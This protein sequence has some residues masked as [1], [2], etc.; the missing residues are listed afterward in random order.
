M[1]RSYAMQFTWFS[2]TSYLNCVCLF[3][4]FL[5]RFDFLFPCRLSLY[6]L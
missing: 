4:W 2:V 6:L 5:M 3:E 1:K